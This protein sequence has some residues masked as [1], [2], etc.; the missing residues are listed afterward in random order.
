MKVGILELLA[1]TPTAGWAEAARHYLTVKQYASIMPQAVAV[2]CRQLGHQVFYATWY[3]QGEP[4]RLLPDDLDVVFIACYTQ[5]SALAYALSR[6]YRRERT[7]TVIGGPHA[8]C[9]PHDCL[10]FFDLVVLQCDKTLVADILGGAFSPHSIISSTRPLTDLPSVEERMP[11]IRASAFFRGRWPYVSTT[12]PLLAS[13][14]CPYTC[15]FCTDWNNP[16]MPLPLDR[17]EADL[18]YLSAHLPTVKIAFHDPNFAVKFDQTLD[19]LERVPP[20]LRNPYIMESSLAVLRGPRLQR[21]HDTHCIYVALGIESWSH[22][23]NKTGVGGKTGSDKVLLLLEHL[24]ALH[25]HVLGI[26]ANFIFGLDTDEGD[27]PMELT[28]EFMSRTPYAWPV[29]NIPVPFGGTPLYDQ[30][31]RN[32]RILTSMPFTFYYSP[33][34]VTTLKNYDPVAYYQKLTDISIHYSSRTML[35]RRLLTTP[36]WSL[37]LLHAVRTAG[38]S[39]RT[40]EFKEI[41]G[42]M[43]TDSRFRAFHEGG[44]PVLPEFYHKQYERMLGPYAPLLSRADRTPELAPMNIPLASGKASPDQQLSEESAPQRQSP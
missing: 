35:W 30:Y 11:E 21:L 14:G 9:F 3:G 38:M 44:T 1:D 15:N 33:Y 18:Q 41:L 7:L 10:R 36:T 8:R 19:V 40:R 27:E 6:L 22:Y 20:R 13:V 4:K 31:L 2:W 12:V 17:L 37:R 32:G 39:E 16:Y 26:Q 5:A 42:L 24:E 43:T 23:S 34:L 29:V 28:K 25:E